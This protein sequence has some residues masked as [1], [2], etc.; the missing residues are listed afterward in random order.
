MLEPVSLSL[1]ARLNVVACDRLFPFFYSTLQSQSYTHR[2]RVRVVPLTDFFF[3]A[4]C[5]WVF[6]GRQIE[7]TLPIAFLRN[8]CFIPLIFF[9]SIFLASVILRLW[10]IYKPLKQQSKFPHIHLVLIIKFL[11]RS[12]FYLLRWKSLWVICFFSF[13]QTKRKL[14]GSDDDF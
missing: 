11:A 13:L 2:A 4:L 1:S 8:S 10:L 9:F 14:S 3:F 12:L 5:V 6:H 7:L